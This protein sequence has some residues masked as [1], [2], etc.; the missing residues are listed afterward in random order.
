MRV[1]IYA[2]LK[3]RPRPHVIVVLTDGYTPWGDVPVRG[4]KVVAGIVGG[5]N[6]NVPDWVQ[7]VQVREG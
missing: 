6:T 4:V 2:A 1:G 3:L 7:V 5:G